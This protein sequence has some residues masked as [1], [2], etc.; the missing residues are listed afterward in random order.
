MSKSFILSALFLLI[1]GVLSAADNINYRTFEN[2]TLNSDAAEINCFAQDPQGIIW[3]GSGKGLYSY[4]GY[5]A[6]QHFEFNDITN[7]RI[8]CIKILNNEH[9]CIGSDNG[10][11]FYNYKTDSYSKREVEFPSDV[12]SM[13]VRDSVLWIGSLK[14]LFKYNLKTK[15]LTEVSKAQ[16]S[17]LPHKTIYSIIRSSD[18]DIYIGTYN[19]LSKYNHDDNNYSVIQLPAN[20]KKNNQFIN[21]LLEDTT[22]RCIWIGTEGA[23]YKY[24]IKEQISKRIDSFNNNSIKSLAIDINNNL[25]IGTDNGLYVYN[26]ENDKVQHVVHDSRDDKSL[27]NNIIWGIF[28]DRQNNIWLGTDYGIS[29]FH[30]SNVFRIIPISQITGVGAG[31]R[32]HSIFRDSHGYF[33]LGGTNGIIR[34]PEIPDITGKSIWY[35]MG[36][37]HYPIS[38]NRI[39]YI[40]EDY[41]RNLWIATDGSINKYDYNKQQFINYNIVDSTYSYNSNWVYH[42][43]EDND[44]FLWIATCLGGI[45]VADKQKLLQSSGHY[46]ADKNYST[47]NGLSGDFINQIIK[48]KSGNVWVLLYN[49]GIDKINIKENIITK[50]TLT[51]E[52]E[53]ENPN[54]ILCDEEGYIWAGF[55][56]GLAYIDPTN[57]SSEF[58]KFDAFGSSEILSMTEEGE[59]IW[60]ST[61]DGVWVLNKKTKKVLRPNIANISF[62]SSFYDSGTDKIYLGASDILAVLSPV[63]LDEKAP[64]PPITITALYVNG[65]LY[66][67]EIDNEKIS[68]RYT[69][70]LV[71]NHEQNNLSFEFS[72]LTFSRSDG[73]KFVYK[74]DDIDTDWNILNRN[75]NRISFTNLKYGNY[76]LNI[77][78]LDSSGKPFPGNYIL[79]LRITPPWYYTIWAKCFYAILLIGFILWIFNFFRVRNNL[80]IERIEK[81]KTLELSKLKIDF[82]TNVSH[83]FKTPLSMIIAPISKLLS[84][85]KDPIKKRQLEA[86][87]RNAL[88]INSLIGQVLDFN[89]NESTADSQL[90][91]SKVEFIEFAQS[92]FNTYEEGY[93][94][95]NLTFTFRS[96]HEKIYTSIDVVKIESVLNNLLSNACKYSEKDGEINLLIVYREDRKLM[97]IT[98]SDKGIGIP[99]KELPYI[100]ERFFQS[101][102]TSKYKE[103]TGI[104]LHLVKKYVEQHNGQA[105]VSSRENEGCSVKVVIPIITN[106]PINL[107]DT[108]NPCENDKNKPLVLIVEDNREIAEFINKMLSL[109]CRCIIAHNGKTGL[110]LC[111]EHSPDII[112]ADIMM[113]I[114]DGLE[115]SRK[116]KRHTPTSTIPIILLTAKDDKQTELESI[117]L[118]VDAFI[119]KP[120]E[121]NILI[122]RIEQLLRNKQQVE[123]KIRIEAIIEPKA[124]EA[125]SPDEKFLSEIVR[126]IED[127]IDD[128]ELNVNY[129]SAISGVSTKQIYRKIKQLT[130]MSPV[131]Y[132]RSIRMKKAA[133]LLSQNKFTIAEVMYMVGFSNHSY[134][135]KCFH[136]EF[137]KTPR[138][139]IESGK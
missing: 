39:R 12:R 55:R 91:L 83:E 121:P 108:P 43:F 26:D 48:D 112:I 9:L 74:L 102:K 45:L 97:E 136:S 38:H 20:E 35:K 64:D 54:Y 33:W 80:R 59:N 133:M 8:Y 99:E 130:G 111:L 100:F 17:G 11:F 53:N 120:F 98:V 21:S 40:Y 72:D 46:I 79:Q 77:A 69:N 37:K 87:Q 134:F 110:D 51:H 116:I 23:L 50:I 101:S 57:N 58:I 22:R 125:T 61:T 123:E 126:I 118:N 68:I 139:Y 19:G 30:N 92:L 117:N 41:D 93:K 75:T 96:S 10:I 18:D 104:G 105:T 137:G 132:I 65:K 25:L 114:M 28:A 86:V 42:I 107:D 49:N 73:N 94:D 5:T 36:D 71:L 60:I 14:G 90:I 47:K 84:D 15:Q 127:H 78:R 135:S 44:S 88:K 3:I 85:I 103:G 95:K 1:T 122:S 52:A 16:S 106:E 129:L 67:P 7:T 124:I 119:A 82:F 2:I 24:N 76:K 63:I 138:Q 115:M 27:C 70:S 29:L 34:T 4:D 131:E 128:T 109:R 31:N 89:R 56:G 6:L 66:H 62:T 13:I 81:E 113:P 32:F